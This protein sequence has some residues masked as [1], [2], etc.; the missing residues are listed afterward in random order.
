MI[1][2]EPRPGDRKPPTPP[3]IPVED[4]TTEALEPDSANCLSCHG[5]R[6]PDPHRCPPESHPTR[7]RAAGADRRDAS[8][9]ISP[10]AT[11]RRPPK[12]SLSPERA[13]ARATSGAAS[14]PASPAGTGAPEE[15][16]P[17]TGRR[18]A[19]IAGI[20]LLVGALVIGGRDAPQLAAA[21]RRRCR[22]PP[23][24]EPHSHGDH[25]GTETPEAG[26]SRP[27]PLG[28]GAARRRKRSLNRRRRRLSSAWSRRSRATT[29]CFPKNLRQR[30]A[31]DDGRLPGEPCRGARRLSGVL[32]GGL[33]CHGRRRA[34]DRARSRARRL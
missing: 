5:R 10:L 9:S 14:A 2:V 19:V 4:V 34:R 29:R 6:S 7:R 3:T 25:P 30:V 31:V 20:V 13:S 8:A 23:D 15:P 21:N 11:S 16:A 17:R 1:P 22:R 32:G 28:G 12:R 26:R 24:S 33:R 27:L 18:A